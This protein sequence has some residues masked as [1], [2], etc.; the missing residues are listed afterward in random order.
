MRKPCVLLFGDMD[1][2]SYTLTPT[3]LEYFCINYGDQRVFQF[4][5]ISALKAIIIMASGITLESK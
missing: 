4:E 2:N 1:N 3:T 5:I